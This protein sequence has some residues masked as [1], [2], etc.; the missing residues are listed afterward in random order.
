MLTGPL[1]RTAVLLPVRDGI[2]DGPRQGRRCPKTTPTLLGSI[3]GG[4]VRVTRIRAD[5]SHA[6]LTEDLVISAS[7]DQAVLTP[8]RQLTKEIGEPLCPVWDG[9]TQVGTAPRSEAIAKGRQ[10]ED[11]ASFTCK[12]ARSG[13]GS[14]FPSMLGLGALAS[15]LALVVVRARKKS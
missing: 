3:S 8:F 12:T 6:A 10:S 9:C 14:S 4:S 2:P 5:L 15:F 13:A 1:E 7:K 11:T